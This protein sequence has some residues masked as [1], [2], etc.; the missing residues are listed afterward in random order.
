MFSEPC[1][2]NIV[3][4]LVSSF[5]SG[6]FINEA[7]ALRII[8]QSTK[9]KLQDVEGKIFT[10]IFDASQDKT[11]IHFYKELTRKAH[12]YMSPVY[13]RDQKIMNQL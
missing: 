2:R 9:Q 11:N 5:E 6:L 4:N 8:I 3:F 13:E 12:E 10:D 7:T 1:K